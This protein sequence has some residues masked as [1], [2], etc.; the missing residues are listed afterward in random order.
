MDMKK[1]LVQPELL[2]FSS[3]CIFLQRWTNSQGSVHNIFF[4]L[5]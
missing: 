4:V 3:A 2:Q 1:A 5:R